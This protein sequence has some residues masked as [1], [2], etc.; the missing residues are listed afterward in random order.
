[1]AECERM[2]AAYYIALHLAMDTF[3][4]HVHHLQGLREPV[5]L[6]N[7]LPEDFRRRHLPTMRIDRLRKDRRV[8]LQW[9]RDN[10][11]QD[12]LT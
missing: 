2:T 8:Q 3:T 5:M 9:V 12:R 4:I 6:G 10:I 11:I 1:M 7:L